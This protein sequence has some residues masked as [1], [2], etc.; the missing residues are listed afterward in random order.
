MRRR[1]GV[2]SETSATAAARSQIPVFFSSFSDVFLG[3]FDFFSAFWGVSRDRPQVNL[4]RFWGYL[5][6]FVGIVFV[7]KNENSGKIKRSEKSSRMNS[8]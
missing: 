8:K 2:E 7:L 6:N 3:G 5:G 1:V 4:S